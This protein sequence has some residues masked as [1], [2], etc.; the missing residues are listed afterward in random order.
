MHGSETF[1]E[2]A[3]AE[4]ADASRF[5]FGRTALVTVLY[6]SGDVLPDFLESLSRQ[7]DQ[8]WA[9]IAVDNASTDNSVEQ[10]ERWQG[11]LHAVVRNTQNH[12]FSKA[13][14][15][16]IVVAMEAGFDAV[17]LINNDTVFDSEFLA[18]LLQSPHRVD[19]PILSPVIYYESEPTRF[20]FAQG[21]FTRWRG[22]MQSFMV[23]SVPDANGGVPESWLTDFIPGCA[24]LISRS[25]IEKIGL[26]DEQF[27]V[28]WE[29]T[30]YC[31]RCKLAGVP[32][33]V[34]RDV[35]MLHK[36]SVLTEGPTSPFSIRMYQRNQIRFIRKHFGEAATWM[37]M[38]AVLAKCVAR[39]VTRR[40]DMRQSKIRLGAVFQE[41]L[42]RPT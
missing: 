41:L 6:N 37:Q 22:A 2:R 13:T 30:D 3:D 26:F 17:V 20:W 18:G 42:T 9:L 40:D 14:N 31:W 34:L 35:K 36:V 27:F 4:I 32:M 24:K 7:T 39:L 33:R 25:A 21:R 8:S 23:E 19:T 28:Y 12:G 11:P 10:V 38:P 29:D 5:R 15:Q 1:F 16:G